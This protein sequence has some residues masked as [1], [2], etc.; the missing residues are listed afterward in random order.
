MRSYM[1]RVLWQR[2][3]LEQEDVIL[4]CRIYLYTSINY[5]QIGYEIYN[6]VEGVL[7]LATEHVRLDSRMLTYPRVAKS[8]ILLK[9]IPS[10]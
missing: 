3:L 10:F 7:T 6:L 8:I 4:D 1:R 9:H 2:R 5:S